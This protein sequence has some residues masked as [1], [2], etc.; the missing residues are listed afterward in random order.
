VDLAWNAA[1]DETGGE[2]DVQRYVIWR[3]LNTELAFGDPYLSIPPAGLAT[4]GHTDRDVVSGSTYIYG[5]A[6]QDCTPLTSTRVESFQ[7]NI[8]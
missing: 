8:P 7:V 2:K 6:A 1:T 4:Y 5:L 3:R